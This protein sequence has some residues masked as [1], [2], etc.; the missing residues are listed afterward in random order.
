MVLGLCHWHI[1][2]ICIGGLHTAANSERLHCNLSHIDKEGEP[3]M[4]DVTHKQV[5]TRT[6]VAEGS[7]MLSDDA[8]EMVLNP[9]TN[10]KGSVVTVARIAAIMAVKK[11]PDL[12]PLCHGL[13]VSGVD[14][15]VAVGK[16]SNVMT[17][18]VCVKS[19]GV[20]GV[21]MEAL[22][23]VSTALLTIYDMTKSVSHEH[24]INDIRLLQKT[25]GKTIL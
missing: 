19:V 20:T 7:I 4:V 18:T 16:Q 14:V 17:V 9:S 25:G 6:A 13:S 15:A 3:N 1:P 5:T 22:V 24:I 2:V 11:T 8:L 23:G 12:I 21:E 10:P